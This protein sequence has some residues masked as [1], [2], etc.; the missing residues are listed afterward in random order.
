MLIKFTIH[1]F[2][3][4]IQIIK[5]LSCA[6]NALQSWNS[7][8][9]KNKLIQSVS[10]HNGEELIQVFVPYNDEILHIHAQQPHTHIIFDNC[11]S[12]ALSIAPQTVEH[13]ICKFK[14]INNKTKQK[15]LVITVPLE[16]VKRSNIDFLK[17]NTHK[18][19]VKKLPQYLIFDFKE[20][21]KL[22]EQL[23]L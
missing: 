2:E 7:I 17:K 23:Y 13:N 22:Q 15:N 14:I 19:L 10:L 12:H 16:A 5:Q 18:F 1:N 3:C 6:T 8:S 21:L 20:E 9:S 11:L 4:T